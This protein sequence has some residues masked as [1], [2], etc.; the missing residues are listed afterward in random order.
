LSRQSW[1]TNTALLLTL[2]FASCQSSGARLDLARDY[3]NIGNAYSD[4]KEYEKAAAYYKRALDLDPA[5]NQAAYNLARTSLEI[6]EYDFAIK[7]LTD[8]EKKDGANL[9]I[10]EMLGFSWYQAGNDEK[11]AKYYRKSL[12]IDPA[13]LRSLYNMSLLEKQNSNWAVSREYLERLLE[14]E[15]K[16]EYRVLLAELAVAMEDRET[17]IL[18]YEDLIVEYD[19]DSETYLAMKDLYL[20]T[21]RY[22]KALDMLELLVETGA[23]PDTISGYYFE[24]SKLE[25]EILD[26]PI[27]GQMSLKSALEKGYS[28]KEKLLELIEL[29]EVSFKT[30]VK[31]LIEEYISLD[32]SVEEENSAESESETDSGTIKLDKAATEKAIL[33]AGN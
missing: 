26:D 10:L 4:L 6:E 33:D 17:A 7:L 1:V 3:Y 19:G 21:E 2:L 13:N 24:K 8:L 5:I 29:V 23:E 31:T 22:Y 11:A 28:D 16:K 14:L 12:D 25:I 18:Y 27:N 32:E 15:E 30:D 9:M 20:E